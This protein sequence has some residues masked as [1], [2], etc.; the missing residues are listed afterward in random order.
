MGVD[1]RLIVA[2]TV[3]FA[4]VACSADSAS[5][6]ADDTPYGQYCMSFFTK[7]RTAKTVGKDHVSVAWKFQ[8]FDWSK[9]RGAD[10]RYHE[11]PQG[12]TKSQIANTLCIKYGWAEDHHIALGIPHFMN[13]YDLPG[14]KG[15]D[16]R[17]I[18]NIYMFEKWNIIKETK[19]MPGVALDYWYYFPSGDTDR[20]LGTDDGAHKV[21]IE[22]SKRWKRLSLHLNPNYMWNEDRDADVG[23]V[24][25]GAIWHLDPKFWPAIEY[26]YYDKEGKGHRH[27]IVPGLIWKFQPNWSFK[28]GVPIDVDTT[29]TDRDRVGIVAKL[30][31]RH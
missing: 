6:V 18:G 20:M 14:T 26:N 27:D 28:V 13:D 29:F 15:N 23:E 22:V 9:T 21:S 31:V 17:G 10:N 3:V 12:Q 19:N 24:N 25:A 30:F 5:T 2:L 8:H 1:G 16:S 11:R 4:S 7:T